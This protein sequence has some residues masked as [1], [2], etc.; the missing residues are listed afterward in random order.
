MIVE[1]E[2]EAK[3]LAMKPSPI[4]MCSASRIP[5]QAAEEP[6]ATSAPREP[7]A[8]SQSRFTFDL[9]QGI[10]FWSLPSSPRRS[11]RVA[12]SIRSAREMNVII[13]IGAKAR[14]FTEGGFLLLV[15]Q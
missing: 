11:S 1:T 7:K 8:N 3:A 4:F 14:R 12:S 5:L 10:R 2:N 9:N 15:I 6:S 13:P